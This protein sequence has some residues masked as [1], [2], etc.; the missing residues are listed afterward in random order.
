MTES[1]WINKEGDRWNAR[2]LRLLL[3]SLPHGHYRVTVTDQA[4]KRSTGM[5]DF[6]HL[7]WRL[8]AKMLNQ[9]QA[10]GPQIHRWD[11]EDVKEWTLGMFAPNV[12]VVDPNGEIHERRKRSHEFTQEEADEFTNVVAL[13]MRDTFGI[14]IED[15]DEQ[16][17][18]PI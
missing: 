3:D 16:V 17:E 12:Q 9:L 8:Y 13:Y 7:C 10:T 6:L 18:L 2:S 11:M 5:N 14:R 15:K 1:L 4:G